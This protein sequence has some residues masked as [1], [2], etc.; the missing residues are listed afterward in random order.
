MAY[1][2]TDQSQV[3]TARIVY[4]FG[5]RYPQIDLLQRLRALSINAAV[6]VIMGLALGAAYTS[7]SELQDQVPLDFMHFLVPVF[8]LLE[9]PVGV[10]GILVSSLLAG[11]M[12]S[13]DSA[14]N[15][16]SAVTMRDFVER[17]RQLSERQSLMLGRATTLVCGVIIIGFAFLVGNISDTAVF[18]R[19]W[20]L[21]GLLVAVLTSHVVSLL[22]SSR[23]P[24]E[25]ARYTLSGSGFFQDQKL[26][27][28]GYSWLLVYFLV[29]LGIMFALDYFAVAVLPG[30]Q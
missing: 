12:S 22:I 9:L 20:D 18:W 6:P 28:R 19:W 21:F 5:N 29:L 30:M 27:W 4:Q 26:W 3:G 24:L 11:A 25:A 1:Y 23:L 17:N 10:R 13:L 2:A 15:S 14:P 7:S 16:L 8:I